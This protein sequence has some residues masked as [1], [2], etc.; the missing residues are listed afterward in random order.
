MQSINEDDIDHEKH[1][2]VTLLT[3]DEKSTNDYCYTLK[4]L[5]DHAVLKPNSPLL[6]FHQD[7]FPDANKNVIRQCTTNPLHFHLVDFSFPPDFNPKIEISLGNKVAGLGTRKD[8][9]SR[10]MWGYAHMIHFFTLGLFQ[11]P[12]VQ[13]YTTLMRLDSDSCFKAS[14]NDDPDDIYL[15]GIRGRYVYRTDAMGLGV[16]TW[17]TDLYDFAVWYMDQN[18]I[19]PRNTALWEHIQTTWTNDATLPIFSKNFEVAGVSFFRRTDVMNWHRALAT[20]EPFGLYRYRWSDANTRVFT[21]ALF[22]EPDWIL[23]KKHPGYRHG[24]ECVTS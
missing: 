7:D 16:N 5:H 23:Y 12:A 14:Q 9:A 11:H 24:K 20:Q 8:A 13:S 19:T 22:A 10:K 3:S 18:A 1:A 15:P 4:T 17:V 2:I 21:M 6:L